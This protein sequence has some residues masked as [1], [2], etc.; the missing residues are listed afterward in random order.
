VS[1]QDVSTILAYTFGVN[2]GRGANPKVGHNQFP[3]R[4]IPSQGG[5]IEIDC[6]LLCRSAPF[7]VGTYRYD[8]T[9]HSLVL[10]S[11][12]DPGPI[13]DEVLSQSEMRSAP[14]YIAVTARLENVVWKYGISSYRYAHVDAGVAVQQMYL[15]ASALG[16]Q[17]CAI[18]GFRER[19]LGV[20]L[21]L[22]DPSE[23]TVVLFVLGRPLRPP[24]YE[25]T[26]RRH[27]PADELDTSGSY[28]RREPR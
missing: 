5:L 19:E 3:Y 28:P 4:W 1:A 13:L 6:H 2:R 11:D 12:S 22:D 14:V 7:A 17:A 8:P 16:L 9:G 26:R 18:S 23:F 25:E 21:H 27:E 10:E 24:Q 20:R 15:L